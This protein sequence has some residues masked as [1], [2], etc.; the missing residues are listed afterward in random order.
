MSSQL[1]NC[2]IKFQLLHIISGLALGVLVIEAGLRSGSLSTAN[3]ALNQGK[4]LFVVPGSPLDP[5]CQGCNLLIKKGAY[6]VENTNDILSEL[7]NLINNQLIEAN[8]TSTLKKEKPL[9]KITDIA[10]N[11]NKLL[12]SQPIHVEELAMQL[13]IP[14]HLINQ[15]IVELELAGFAERRL[16][17]M[18]CCVN[19]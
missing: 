3:Y 13:N 15:A 8:K 16:G 1:Y 19:P 14:L 18:V 9:V 10:N 2:K 7:P 11:L 6:L 5:R 17:N 12:S 4:E